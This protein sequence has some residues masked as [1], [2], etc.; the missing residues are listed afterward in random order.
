ML[1]KKKTFSCNKCYRTSGLPGK[2]QITKGRS[3]SLVNI[4]R[5]QKTWN[6]WMVHTNVHWAIPTLNKWSKASANL[7]KEM[8]L[9]GTS[10]WAQICQVFLTLLEI[11]CC[12]HPCCPYHHLTDR[13][14]KP[15]FSQHMFFSS[16]RVK[17]NNDKPLASGLPK[18]YDE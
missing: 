18:H 16:Q 6:S 10:S 7:W 1:N 15:L 8:T 4:M 12:R 17:C 13:G 11:F 5:F 9:Y 2:I 14:R 3:C